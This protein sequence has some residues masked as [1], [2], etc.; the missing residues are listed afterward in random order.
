MRR[1]DTTTALIADDHGLYR[2]G[3]SLLLRDSLAFQDVIDAPNFDEALD[4]LAARPDI[5][6]A[7]FDL[8]MPGIGGP[9]SLGVVREAYPK[10]RV[11]IISASES[12]D[13]VMRAISTGVLGFIPKSL[14]ESEI[15]AAL[16]SILEDRI[17]IPK[18]MSSARPFVAGP[19][20]QPVSARNETASSISVRLTPRQSDV[21]AGIVR[22]LSNKEIARELDIAEGTVKIHLAALFSHFGARNRTE[23][24]MRAPPT[25]S[26]PG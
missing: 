11:A 12:R 17:Y 15:V 5:G 18:F 14:P 4:K 7:L 21:L 26:K 19:A 22:G 24:A 10:V 6:L 20:R 13:D 9:E 25:K 16:Q 2:T 3:L 1:S 8:G 23:L